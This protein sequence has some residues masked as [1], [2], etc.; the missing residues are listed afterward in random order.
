MEVCGN[1]PSKVVS[2]ITSSFTH[3]PRESPDGGQGE[4]LRVYP[5]FLCVSSGVRKNGLVASRTVKEIMMGLRTVFWLVVLGCFAV[6]VR[7]HFGKNCGSSWVCFA[8]GCLGSGLSLFG[9]GGRVGV[10]W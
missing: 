8:M 4:V 1:D 10:A 6:Q 5:F 7:A 9:A 2:S 3:Q